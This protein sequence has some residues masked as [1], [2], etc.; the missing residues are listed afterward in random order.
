MLYISY[1]VIFFH[2]SGITVL[3]FAAFQKVKL[4]H[5]SQGRTQSVLGAERNRFLSQDANTLHEHPP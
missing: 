4:S 3:I 1:C 5:T 2:L